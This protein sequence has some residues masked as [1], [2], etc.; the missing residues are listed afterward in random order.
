MLMARKLPTLLEKE[1]LVS[2]LDL[3]AETNKIYKD[4]KRLLI[5]KLRP[6]VPSTET[7]SC[8]EKQHCCTLYVHELKRLLD[9]AMPHLDADN[10]DRILFQ[11]L[12]AGSPTTAV[13]RFKDRS[14]VT[15]DVIQLRPI[16]SYCSCL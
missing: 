11:Q 10:Q 6:S 16:W 13:A 2:W 15:G 9:D 1:A 14:P 12:L 4:V 7:A 5:E 3:P 8:M